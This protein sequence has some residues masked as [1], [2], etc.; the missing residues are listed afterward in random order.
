MSLLSDTAGQA[1]GST[2]RE[3]IMAALTLTKTRSLILDTF[4]FATLGMV[5]QHAHLTAPVI[6]M[7]RVNAPEQY[8][9]DTRAASRRLWGSVTATGTRDMHGTVTPQERRGLAS[10]FAFVNAAGQRLRWI[11]END[12]TELIWL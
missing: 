2:E 5:Q 7:Q 3:H 9:A 10:G 4:P 1:G 12:G 8:A 6:R 11:G